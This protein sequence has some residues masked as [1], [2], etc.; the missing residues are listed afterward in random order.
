M[1]ARRQKVRIHF[2]VALTLAVCA[3]GGSRFLR[4]CRH[5]QEQTDRT[6]IEQ[7][8]RAYVSDL[9]HSAQHQQLESLALIGPGQVGRDAAALLM[10][11]RYLAEQDQP[12]RPP[13]PIPGRAQALAEI[14]ANFSRLRAGEPAAFPRGQSFLRGY[15]AALDGTFQP[16]SVNIP[17]S[18][19]GTRPYPVIVSLHGHMGFRPFQCVGAPAYEGALSVR[20]EGRGATDY[21]YVGEDDV[22][23]VLREVRSIYNVDGERIYLTGSSMG[24]TGCWNLAVH[25]PDLFAGIVPIAGNADHRAWEQRWAWNQ[26]GLSRHAELR[27]FLHAAFSP[28]SYAENLEHCNIA[29]V[30]GTG[31]QVVPVE[32][33]RSMAAR[34]RELGYTFEYLEF[35]GAGHGGFP[36]WAADYALAK[37]FG[38]PPAEV[39]ARLRHRTAS[40]RENGAWWVRVDRLDSP[41][42]FAEVRAEL[43]AGGVAELRTDNVSALAVL[44]G[45][46][47][48]PVQGVRVDGAEFAVPADVE[49]GELALEKWGGTWRVA[50]EHGL[51]KRKGLSGPLGD[52]LRDP[53]LVVLGTASDSELHKDICQR[54]ATRFAADWQER[55]GEAPRLK[56]DAELTEQD[57]SDYNLLLFGGP[58]ANSV[59][60]RLM[61]RLPVRVEGDA[62]VVGEERYAGDDVGL[63][64]CYPNPENPQRMVAVV[65]GTTP[66]ALYQAYDRTGLWFDWGI[67]DKYKWF[68]YAVYDSRTAGPESFLTVGFFDNLWQLAPQG[69]TPAGGGIAWQGLPEARDSA[70]PQ[71][72]PALKSAAEAQEDQVHLSDVRPLTISQYRGAVGFDRSYWGSAIRLGEE[73]FDK[74][75]GIRPPSSLSFALGGPFR[76][77]TA[78]V[79]LMRG[80]G[81]ALSPARVAAEE[82]VFE[83]Y[84]DDRLLASSGPLNWG[85][86]GSSRA[87]LR[88]SLT[89]VGVLTLIARPTG[90]ATWLLGEAAWADPVVTR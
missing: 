2:L 67:Y 1:A 25:Y 43:P 26:G 14:K 61:P 3:L 32:H 71:R 48:A 50:S 17:Q 58:S 81:E 84:G 18:Y 30:H 57:V 15:Y 72:F 76:E 29:I 60:A 82:V 42:R 36:A 16:Y 64:A 63:M 59:T 83:V 80:S 44:A 23:A 13:R 40:L 33:A 5:Q 8:L 65:A 89:G 39:P 78:K 77:F 51:A 88:A 9:L 87:L 54:E 62:V 68:D 10:Q 21:M 90:A 86:G 79:G 28:V 46:A 38:R 22:L 69:G 52:V 85:E 74:G 27:S 45:R 37:V 73:E 34:L 66:A 19:D 47:P 55:Y 75:L 53:F 35:P 4:S 12:G 7:E 56:A 49:G 41:V 20:P 24:A 6:Y 70:R 31:D 11:A